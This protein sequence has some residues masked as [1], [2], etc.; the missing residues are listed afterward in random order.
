MAWQQ[1]LDAEQAGFMQELLAFVRIPSVSAKPE[2]ILDMVRAAEWLAARLTAAGVDG[3]GGVADGG[4]SGGL[5]TL[6][7]RGG[8][9]ADDPDLQAF[10]C[11]AC[12][13]V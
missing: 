4:A 1:Y 13:A 11:T 2:N 6:A 5:W 7:A 9:Q 3:G 8:R 12:R 10:R